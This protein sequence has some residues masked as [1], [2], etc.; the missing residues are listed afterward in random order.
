MSKAERDCDKPV[1]N[2]GGYT[3]EFSDRGTKPKKDSVRFRYPNPDKR[4]VGC[5]HSG[6]HKITISES[7]LCEKHRGG[8]DLHPLHERDWLGRVIPPKYTRAEC[9]TDAPEHR[10]IADAL[11]RW[12]GEDQKRLEKLDSFIEDALD[13]M[14]GQ[15]PDATSLRQS[16]DGRLS[17]SMKPD[18]IVE[19]T[20]KLVERH[21]PKMKHEKMCVDGGT[22]FGKQWGDIPIRVVAALLVL[23]YASEEANQGDWWFRKKCFGEGTSKSKPIRSG[24]YMS[25]GWYLYKRYTNP[26]FHDLIRRSL[27]GK[28]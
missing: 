19:L 28:M 18:D 21:F 23:A 7:G 3:V 4:K 12:A 8:E 17:G 11:L 6:C 25:A 16:F 24:C 13:S 2:E 22:C 5:G 9:L 26:D 1:I 15:I 20:N 27:Q 14:I 10:I